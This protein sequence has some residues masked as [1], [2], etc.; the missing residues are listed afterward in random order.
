MAWTVGYSYCFGYRID[1]HINL[2]LGIPTWAFWGIAVPWGIA[3]LVSIVFATW[4]IKD[5][6]P[7]GDRDTYLFQG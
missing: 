7:D 1:A 5:D 3:T 2:T 6:L 4:V